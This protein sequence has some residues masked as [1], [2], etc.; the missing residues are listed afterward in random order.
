MDCAAVARAPKSQGV[1]N[2]HAV[3]D[4]LSHLGDHRSHC[5]PAMARLGRIRPVR[6]VL[7]IRELDRLFARDETGSHRMNY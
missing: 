3:R 4:S 5:E 7:L 1:R 6:L 2:A